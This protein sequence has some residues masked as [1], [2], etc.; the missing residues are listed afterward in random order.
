MVLVVVE[1]WYIILVEVNFILVIFYYYE[2][3]LFVRCVVDEK[4]IMFNLD[5]IIIFFFLILE[6]KSCMLRYRKYLFLKVEICLIFFIVYL[7]I[8]NNYKDNFDY[9]DC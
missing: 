9:I 6:K 4:I 7:V 2:L 8:L 1:V 5:I 3:F